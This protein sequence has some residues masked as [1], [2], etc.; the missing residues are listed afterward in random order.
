MNR[1]AIQL[2]RLHNL[3]QTMRDAAKDK[4][5]RS[6]FTMDRFGWLVNISNYIHQE[7]FLL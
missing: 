2:K 4:V 6:K 7:L 1:T 5:M 3:V